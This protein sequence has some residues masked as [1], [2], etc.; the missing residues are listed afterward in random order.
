MSFYAAL[1]ISILGFFQVG[2]WLTC[3]ISLI[4]FLI[5]SFYP[6]DDKDDAWVCKLMSFLM[7]FMLFS[8]SLFIVETA[9]SVVSCDNIQCP[10]CN[11]EIK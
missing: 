8:T 10:V 5:K 2:I 7:G 4:F 1:E 11:K 6:P 3:F 9:R